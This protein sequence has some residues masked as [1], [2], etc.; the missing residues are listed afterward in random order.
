[1]CGVCGGFS[2]DA[3]K[4][5][6]AL[7][8]RG[9][10]AD[11][12]IRVGSL[13]LGHTRLSIIDLD[14]RSDQPFVRGDVSLSYNGELWNYKEL[15]LEL[16][17]LGHEFSTT[18]DTEVFAAAL[19][20]WGEEALPKTNGMFAVAWTKDGG[21]T[22]KLARDRFGEVPLHFAAQRPFMFA[23]EIK[24][25]L[26]MGA[27]PKSIQWVEPGTVIEASK[28]WITV[29]RWH[30]ISLDSIPDRIE[31]GAVQI[32]SLIECGVLDRTISDV[33]VCTLLSGG[34]DSS[35]VLHHLC[36]YFGKV[37]AY[38]AVY[39]ER[40]RDLQCAR[41]VAETCEVELREIR[42]PLPSAEDLA[43]VVRACEMPHKAQ[44]EI[45]WPCLCL[46]REMRRD[47]F[48]VTYSGEGSDE[49][50]ASYGF[51]Y[52]GVAKEGWHAYRKNLFLGQHRKNFARCNK[53]FMAHSVECRLPFLQ[54]ELV[55]Y[56]VSLTRDAVEGPDRRQKDVLK[57]AYREI[58]PLSVVDRPKIAFQDGMGIKKAIADVLP[59]PKR[60]YAAEFRLA[61]R[62]AMI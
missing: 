44:V 35:A 42:V 50:W 13:F 49:L 25:L 17:G 22:V 24:A 12:F 31:K 55:Q 20:E 10:D 54:P 39:N 45:G 14:S 59:D 33:P 4:G 1:M 16:E 37:V 43:S 8:H 9:P 34:I 18:G 36:Q 28:D 46:A 53:I 11:G 26:K 57:R 3:E 56:A 41:E 6:A 61:F 7:A 2:K 38:T 15:R 48:K 29:R 27:N 58:L 60:F 52:Y 47:G 5:I 51:A 23:S 62:G 40:S 21:R 19:Q 32:R 30:D